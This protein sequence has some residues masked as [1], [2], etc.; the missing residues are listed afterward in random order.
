[1]LTISFSRFIPNFLQKQLFLTIASHSIYAPLSPLISIFSFVFIPSH[2]SYILII[3]HPSFLLNLLPFFRFPFPGYSNSYFLL[4]TRFSTNST[5]NL[6]GIYL[7][8]FVSFLFYCC[9]LISSLSQSY[10]RI[11]TMWV[12]EAYLWNL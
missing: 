12:F 10:S 8:P 11:V 7:L 1:M 9:S 2:L 6:P 4:L 5:G 3:Y